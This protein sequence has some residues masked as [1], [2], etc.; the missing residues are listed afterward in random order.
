MTSKIDYALRVRQLVRRSFYYHT[1]A[2]LEF[3]LPGINMQRSFERDVEGNVIFEIQAKHPDV[4]ISLKIPPHVTREE[5]LRFLRFFAHQ[6][7]ME[8]EEWG[9]MGKDT[10]E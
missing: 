4:T 3:G 9:G 8:Y 7:E 6:V 10:D 2:E 5:L 1:I